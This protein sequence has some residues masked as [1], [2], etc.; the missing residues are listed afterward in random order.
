MITEKVDSYVV[1]GNV[2]LLNHIEYLFVL[3][4]MVEC[5]KRI[6]EISNC[7]RVRLTIEINFSNLQMST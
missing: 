2:E 5:Q 1:V 4:A 6:Q 7:E 3:C